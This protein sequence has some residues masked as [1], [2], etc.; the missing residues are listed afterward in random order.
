MRQH[1]ARRSAFADVRG[2]NA[3]AVA[4]VA[5]VL[6]HANGEIDAGG[7]KSLARRD[8]IEARSKARQELEELL[9]V[10]QFGG[11]VLQEID[12]LA[13]PEICF[14]F[15]LVA[16]LDQRGKVRVAVCFRPAA[17]S[18]AGKLADHE[19]GG[20]SFTQVE[21]AC[22][23]NPSTGSSPA[24][25]D[26]RGQDR[27][28]T[29]VVD[30]RMPAESPGRY[31]TPEPVRSSSMW[32]VSFSELEPVRRRFSRTVAGYGWL[33]VQVVVGVSSVPVPSD[34]I[35]FQPPSQPVSLLLL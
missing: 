3:L 12:E 16:G 34:C 25:Q 9:R 1:A 31:S 4:A 32:R 21:S 10:V 17:Q 27:Q 35:L 30:G 13:A 8:G 24:K 22:R 11:A 29:Q 28:P 20:E 5:L 6:D 18:G 14:E 7:M 26:A 19:P 15:F 23:R 33:R 2:A